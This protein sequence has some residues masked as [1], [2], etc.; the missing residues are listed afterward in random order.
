M[1]LSTWDL[2]QISLCPK[3]FL[4]SPVARDQ[5]DPARVIAKKAILLRA[6]GRTTGWT[7]AGIARAWDEIFWAG[8]E[9]TKENLD[10]SVRGILATRG[11]FRSLPDKGFIAH[12]PLEIETQMDSS[13]YLSSMSDFI[14]SYEDRYESWI[15]LKASPKEIRRSPIPAVEHYLIQKREDRDKPFYLV[16]FY[17]STRSMRPIHF[18]I[19]CSLPI[20]ATER[21][22]MS[23]CS[24]ARRNISYPRLG[25]HCKDCEIKC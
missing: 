21:I 1:R 20:S 7:G 19:R 13:I 16:I 14:L 25:E 8:R 9:I 2:Y 4:E 11:L 22:T 12:S 17:S 23:L 24:M 15:Y 6:V 5:G 3:R 10:A 18:R